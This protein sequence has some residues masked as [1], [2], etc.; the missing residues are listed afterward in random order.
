MVIST[1]LETSQGEIDIFAA[2]WPREDFAP[3]LRVIQQMGTAWSF[4]TGRS[5]SRL[6]VGRESV[7]PGEPRML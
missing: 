3:F 7:K 6:N 2:S 1:A 4:D 5:L